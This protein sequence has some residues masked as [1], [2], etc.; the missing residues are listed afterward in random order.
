MKQQRNQ[1][2]HQPER[3][4]PDSARPFNG[5]DQGPLKDVSS[6]L[7][8]SISYNE[9][10]ESQNI[11]T[12]QQRSEPSI[13]SYKESATGAEKHMKNVRMGIRKELQK[14]KSSHIGSTSGVYT[15]PSQP[16]TPP[17]GAGRSNSM[18][19]NAQLYKEFMKDDSK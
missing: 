6:L 7:P 3:S 9:V 2:Y 17:D 15:P 11:T 13:E 18:M 5:T 19:S 16:N 1:S 12:S 4:P 14:F 10:E 8:P